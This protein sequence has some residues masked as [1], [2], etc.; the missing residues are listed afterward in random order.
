M[1][2]INLYKDR[3]QQFSLY[4]SVDQQYMVGI[5]AFDEPKQIRRNRTLLYLFWILPLILCFVADQWYLN[6]WGWEPY[7]ILLGTIISVFL[8]EGIFRK[9]DKKFS[10]YLASLPAETGYNP[11]DTPYLLSQGWRQMRL[12]RT[13]MIVIAV[14]TWCWF[15]TGAYLEVDAMVL[16]LYLYGRF[17]KFGQRAAFYRLLQEKR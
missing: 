8:G 5:F 11:V 16:V 4:A 14:V 7:W 12:Q 3:A 10:L 6:R 17:G 1:Y 13:G 15:W 9:F 2:F